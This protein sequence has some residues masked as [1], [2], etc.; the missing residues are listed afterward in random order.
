MGDAKLVTT[1]GDYAAV[2]AGLGKLIAS[3]PQGQVMDVFNSFSKITSPVVPNLL[4]SKVDPGA[5]QSA[6][7]ALLTFKDAVKAAQRRAGAAQSA[8]GALL[9][10]KDAVQRSSARKCEL[11]AY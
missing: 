1:E 7:G 9:A 3:V 5:A 8:F 2:L 11:F 10:C 6:F 4:Y